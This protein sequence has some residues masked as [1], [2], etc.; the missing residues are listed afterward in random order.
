MVTTSVSVLEGDV[1][2]TSR[3]AEI[4]VSQGC[5]CIYVPDTLFIESFWCFCLLVSTLEINLS[6]YPV[7]F[8]PPICNRAWFGLNFL[9]VLL[10][11][12][13]VSKVLFKVLYS[14]ISGFALFFAMATGI[15][16]RL[17]VVVIAVD[18]VYH[19]CCCHYFLSHFPV[20]F[21]NISDVLG[22]VDSCDC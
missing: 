20:C 14:V 12:F 17:T 6:Y 15:V 22:V 18:V 16:L 3:R 11:L 1:A 8:L 10:N 19:S 5:H 2:S 4:Q 13:M 9:V 21:P 7:L